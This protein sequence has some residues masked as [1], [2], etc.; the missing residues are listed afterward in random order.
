DGA[1]PADRAA[2]EHTAPARPERRRQAARAG[3][4]GV[5][6]ALPEEEQGS[7]R[8][9]PLVAVV[10]QPDRLPGIPR[11]ELRPALPQRRLQPG[12]LR[13]EPGQGLP[14]PRRR[15]R[16]HGRPQFEP[17]THRRPP[18]RPAPSPATPAPSP[19]TSRRARD[20]YPTPRS[21]TRRSPRAP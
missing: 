7:D 14:R 13:G 9:G 15:I 20:R 19:R 3:P 6:P 8:R 12:P 17:L 5:V 11:E 18:P 10:R 2:G 21:R 4:L 16:R 1:H